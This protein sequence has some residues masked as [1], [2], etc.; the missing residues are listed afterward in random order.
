MKTSFEEIAKAL[1]SGDLDGFTIWPDRKGGW[2]ISSRD[3]ITGGWDTNIDL[4]EIPKPV[5]KQRRTD[6]DDLI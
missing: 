4:V 3:A 1:L 2:Q 5:T 6:Y